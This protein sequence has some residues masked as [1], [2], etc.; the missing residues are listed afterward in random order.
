ML[1]QTDVNYVGNA[2]HLYKIY[3]YIFI[4]T[5][6]RYVLQKSIK[7]I[8][9]Y[10][11]YE[12]ERYKEIVFIKCDTIFNFVFA[13]WWKNI[14]DANLKIFFGKCSCFA[15]CCNGQVRGHPYLVKTVRIHC[16][17][18]AI[19]LHDYGPF[20]TWLRR[21]RGGP[22]SDTRPRYTQVKT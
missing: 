1:T 14:L 16:N 6:F 22:S 12:I 20:V 7:L 9:Y 2:L 5:T 21:W 10:T 4:C 19:S 11:V 8:T 18:E 17:Y 15:K 13:K 3:M